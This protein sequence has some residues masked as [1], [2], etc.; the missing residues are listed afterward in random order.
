MVRNTQKGFAVLETLLIIIILALI[1]S[2]GYFVLSQ[3]HQRLDFND[4]LATIKTDSLHLSSN[5]KSVKSSDFQGYALVTYPAND[6][7]YYVSDY[8]STDKSVYFVVKG[9]DKTVIS[10]WRSKTARTLENNGF[11]TTD[12]MSPSWWYKTP[13]DNKDASIYTRDNLVCVLNDGQTADDSVLVFG[14]KT[15]D[16]MQTGITELAPFVSAYL[17]S[18]KKDPG[19]SRPIMLFPPVI[20]Q[21]K[22]AGYSWA[23]V[24]LPAEGGLFFVKHSDGWK[25]VLMSNEGYT[26]SQLK[27]YGQDVQVALSDSCLDE[28]NAGQ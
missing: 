9:H 26:C 5:I 22:T 8:P 16:E 12:T 4:V 21:S 7:K 3:R 27:V 14:C 18:G 13:Y 17:A 19:V 6:G 2:A 11:K 1:G 15:R 23:D 28:N 20:T 25:Y 10:D 24:A